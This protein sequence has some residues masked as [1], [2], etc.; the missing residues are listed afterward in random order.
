M[1]KSQADE[2]WDF[3]FTRNLLF[4]CGLKRSGMS[5]KLSFQLTEFL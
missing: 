5:V 1:N 2:A 4:Y 3:K